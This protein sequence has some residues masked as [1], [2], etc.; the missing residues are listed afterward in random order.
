MGKRKQFHKLKHMG[1][2]KKILRKI[3]NMASAVMETLFEQPS[4]GMLPEVSPQYASPRSLREHFR[5]S[6]YSLSPL[7]EQTRHLRVCNPDPSPESSPLLQPELRSAEELLHNGKISP[8]SFELQMSNEEAVLESER[9]D[10]RQALAAEPRLWLE[11]VVEDVEENPGRPSPIERQV[12]RRRHYEEPGSQRQAEETSIPSTSKPLNFRGEHEVRTAV[13]S[14]RAFNPV[15]AEDTPSVPKIQGPGYHYP[16][17]IPK[18]RQESKTIWNLDNEGSAPLDPDLQVIPRAPLEQRLTPRW[19]HRYAT[20]P[21]A[22]LVLPYGYL[23]VPHRKP[24]EKR[25]AKVVSHMA[26]IRDII[27][28]M[29][30]RTEAQTRKPYKQNRAPAITSDPLALGTL[31]T[32]HRGLR[33]WQPLRWAAYAVIE[34]PV[35]HDECQGFTPSRETVKSSDAA[36]HQG[37]RA[38]KENYFLYR[39]YKRQR[40]LQRSSGQWASIIGKLGEVRRFRKTLEDALGDLGKFEVEFP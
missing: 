10:A 35:E 14:L 23:T 8:P 38:T 15:L 31:T 19:K 21:L 18:E 12:S 20:R 5:I 2:V 1:K 34:S 6:E 7:P 32:S 29:K 17:F 22:P 37:R 26:I 24:V 28:R 25:L 30:S 4:G 27:T 3:R 36:W 13:V 40:F 16:K 33:S 11:T 9:E 39:H